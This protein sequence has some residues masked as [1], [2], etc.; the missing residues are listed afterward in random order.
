VQLRSW[1]MASGAGHMAGVAAEAWYPTP[2]GTR[3]ARDAVSSAVTNDPISLERSETPACFLAV[4][5]I[6][7]PFLN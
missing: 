2:S 4:L 5:P 1:V 7:L 6:R 3:N